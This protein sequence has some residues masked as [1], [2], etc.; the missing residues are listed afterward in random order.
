M[1]E[2]IWDVDRRGTVTAPSGA[3]F[4]A[5]DRAASFSPDDLMA[6]AA[7][8][9]LMR[10]FLQLAAEGQVVVLSYAANAHVE[11]GRGPLRPR[12]HVRVYVTASEGTDCRRITLLCEQAAHISPVA[13]MLG[14]R[15]RVEHDVRALCSPPVM[16]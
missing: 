6:A 16:H 1:I 12:V 11:S 2:L 3:C 10:T 13:Q 14:E 15:L 4:D 8:S 9:C 5:G 7:A